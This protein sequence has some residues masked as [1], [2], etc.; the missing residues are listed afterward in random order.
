[1]AQAYANNGDAA[2]AL[3]TVQRG[4]AFVAPTPPGEKPS[5]VRKTLEDQ[6]RD[7]QILIKTGHLPPD[8]NQ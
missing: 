2:K 4:L 5:E 7:I 3:E 6:L 8:F 1:L